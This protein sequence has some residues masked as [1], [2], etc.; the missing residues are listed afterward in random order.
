MRTPREIIIQALNEI[1]EMGLCV[2]NVNVQWLGPFGVTDSN[3]VENF[4]GD[5]SIG[6]KFFYSCSVVDNLGST[7]EGHS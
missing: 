3:R 6:G 5:I 4:V 1:A 2:T 7:P